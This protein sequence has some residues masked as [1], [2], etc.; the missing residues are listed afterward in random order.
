[1]T[2]PRTLW[3]DGAAGL[4]LTLAC[5]APPEAVDLLAATVWGGGRVRYRLLDV[6]AKLARLRDPRFALLE[7][8]GALASVFVL[9]RCRK[10]ALGRTLDGVHFVM[11]ATVPALRG[12]GLAALVAERLRGWCEATLP[13]PG[14]GFAYVEADTEISLRISENVGHALEADLPLVV[15]S[16]LLP[17]ASPTVGTARSDEFEEVVDRLTALYADHEL[18]DSETALRPAET[19]VVREGGRIRAAVAAEAMRWRVEELP[20]AAGRALMRAAPMLPR[21]LRPLDL[22]DLHAVRFGAPLVEPGCEAALVTVMEAAL[23]RAQARIGLLMMDGRSPVLKRILAYGRLGAL[24]RVLKGAAKLRMDFAG[25]SED[26]ITV[27][28]SRPLLVSPADVF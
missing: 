16:R 17:R 11:A 22:E 23:A 12:Q 13:R 21:A 3:E 9:D 8:D 28:R 24:S 19:L 5:T 27:L 10:R 25:L 4:R 20:G 18:S 7:K 14:F 6:E 15:F 2:A 1:M 26:E